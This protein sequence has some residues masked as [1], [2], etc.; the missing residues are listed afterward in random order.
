MKMWIGFVVF[1]EVCLLMSLVLVN[2]DL[3]S[4][5]LQ[6]LPVFLS[7]LPVLFLNRGSGTMKSNSGETMIP[8]TLPPPI[9]TSIRE[10]RRERRHR[11]RDQSRFLNR[12]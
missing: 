2:P 5:V 12:G 8:D 9:T 1:V 6:V 11:L 7:L 10:S 3:Q 4:K